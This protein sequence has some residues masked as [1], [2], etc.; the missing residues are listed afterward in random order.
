MTQVI[1]PHMGVPPTSPEMFKALFEHLAPQGIER[2]MKI[3]VGSAANKLTI[4]LGAWWTAQGDNIVEDSDWTDYFSPETGRPLT[5]NATAFDR[6]DIIVGDYFY[7]SNTGKKATYQIETGTPAAVPVPPVFTNDQIPIAF[8][9]MEAGQSTYTDILR[10]PSIFRWNC[11]LSGGV[12]TLRYGSQN[13]I[14]VI[15]AP[16]DLDWLDL[17]AGV[18]YQMANTDLTGT[19]GAAITTWTTIAG[20][21]EDGDVTLKW[22]V[23]EVIAARGDMSSLGARLDVS[24]DKDGTIKPAALK[25]KIAHGDLTD[26]PD[27]G[28]FTTDNDTW[29]SNHGLS[30]WGPGGSQIPG[31]Y[32]INYQYNGGDRRFRFALGA[33][34]YTDGTEKK[35]YLLTALSKLNWIFVSVQSTLLFVLALG[36][37]DI[38][39]TVTSWGSQNADH[40]AS[41]VRVCDANPDL[42]G[43]LTQFF[44]TRTE[45]EAEQGYI[46][47]LQ[48]DVVTN[49]AA[50][51]A[52]VTARKSALDKIHGD[53]VL[54]GCGYTGLGGG[55]VLAFAS[56]YV[57]SNGAVVTFAGGTTASVTGSNGTKYVVVNA[58]GVLA[59]RTLIAHEGDVYLRTVVVSGL[60]IDV[61]AEKREFVSWPYD[62]NILPVA[63][64]SDVAAETRGGRMLSF[65]GR[66]GM[67]EVL[68][69]D[70]SL[71]SVNIDVVASA[72]NPFE[73]GMAVVLCL[74]GTY[75]FRTVD[76]VGT[77]SVSFASAGLPEPATG[78]IYE[79]K[80]VAENIDSRYRTLTAQGIAWQRDADE[81][82]AL[83][84]GA[85]GGLFGGGFGY[86]A[87]TTFDGDNGNARPV[88]WKAY[89]GAGID[90]T[91]SNWNSV[92]KTA[93]VF[94]GCVLYDGTDGTGW[95]LF[96]DENGALRLT[97]AHVTLSASKG[98]HAYFNL[99]IFLSPKLECFASVGIGH[100]PNLG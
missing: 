40:N 72:D 19:D 87:T 15:V 25:E 89:V 36:T 55:G 13:A 54:S 67:A 16:N 51:T 41:F 49:D 86:T 23:D 28:S 33:W 75:Y 80:T 95:R 20:W 60:T 45:F 90:W 71:D 2:G 26:M 4:E 24:L 69:V 83:P 81:D 46:D 11:Y 76:S 85:D 22:L 7:T 44:P 43:M 73:E 9:L 97:A 100:F 1:R 78:V 98:K 94:T 31:T 38:D 14:R 96:C 70:A 74:S 35:T 84:G 5:A 6:W 79:V 66:L 39:V 17:K 56:G 8:A 32:T 57:L 64:G 59:V 61:N 3:V 12:E 63:D 91:A 68:S 30:V 77:Q 37:K 88:Y 58:A 42:S 50:I 99:D 48:G 92:D 27:T 47:T 93:A 21:D 52:E 29:L 62:R 10:A 18:Y 53:G 82:S 65:V 34:V